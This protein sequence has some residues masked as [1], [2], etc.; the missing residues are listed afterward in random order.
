MTFQVLEERM[1]TLSIDR[2]RGRAIDV[3]GVAAALGSVAIWAGW[4]V[5][6]RHAVTHALDPAAVGLLRFAIPALVFVPV[7]LRLG[8]LPKRVPMLTLIALMGAGA[9]FFLTVAYA[10]QYA[11][12]ADIGPLLPGT[13]P[14]LV[15]LISVVMFGERLG[16]LRLVGLALVAAGIVAI[17]GRGLLAAGDT[18]R[19]HGLLLAGAL[20][21]AV[22][23]H[24]FKR[25]GINAVEATAIVAA[26]STLMLL[27]AGAPALVTAVQQGLALDVIAQTIVQGVLSGVIAIVLYGVA[28]TRLGAARGA[29]F[30][31][32]VP[33]LAALIAIPV[34]G[35]WPDAA[36]TVGI[37]ATAIGVALAAG[38]FDSL[39]S[40]ATPR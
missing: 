3:A 19:G 13:M 1:A 18:W 6:T 40:G 10:M 34:L 11:P 31:A 9:P 4:I 36:A 15:A 27:P 23:T 5:G 26:W 35:E 7:W 38:A 16:R 25:S 33:A 20:M 24:A 28:V 8:L 32:L 29:A 39:P 37:A 30:V 2:P 21:W 17:G 12:A 14:L 22:Y